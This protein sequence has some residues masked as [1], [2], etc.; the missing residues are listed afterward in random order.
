[1]SPAKQKPDMACLS[2]VGLVLVPIVILVVLVFSWLEKAPPEKLAISVKS[3]DGVDTAS[4][5]LVDL[6]ATGGDIYIRLK[7]ASNASAKGEVVVYDNT[8]NILL[9]PIWKGSRTLV[10]SVHDAEGKL[11]QHDRRWHDV[12]IVY[13]KRKYP[14]E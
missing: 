8:A 5:F 10:I 3:P 12:E 11:I 14:A 2:L 7:R 9:S 6:G 1:M 4:E 13:Q